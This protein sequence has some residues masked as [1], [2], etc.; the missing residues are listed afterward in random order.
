VTL[1][2][3]APAG[4]LEQK[5]TGKADRQFLTEAASANLMEV[6]LGRRAATRAA[7]DRVKQFA[8]RMVDDHT[9]ANDDLKQVAG[10]LS[11]TLPATMTK[12]HRQQVDRLSRF[13]GTEFDRAYMQAMLKDHQEDVQK[14][15]RQAESA[16]DPDLKEFASST[17][18][19]LES[20]LQMAQDISAGM[21]KATAGTRRHRD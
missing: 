18:P 14:F 8:Q 21:A 16:T 20:H 6:E 9:K 10:R 7:S 19:T 4:A 12:Q 13:R 2:V 1:L 5:S 15:R 11:V 3:G 17:L